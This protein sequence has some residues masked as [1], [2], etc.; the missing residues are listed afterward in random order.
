ML[1][2]PIRK[3]R[4]L[5]YIGMLALCALLGLV[6]GFAAALIDTFGGPAT[7]ALQTG[8]LTL[9]MG[10]V[11]WICVLWWRAADEAVRE[12]HK[13]AWYWGGSAGIVVVILALGLVGWDVIEL[14]PTVLSGEPTELI[15]T[16]V[17]LTLG[18]QL[19]GYL[20]AW[21]AWWLRHR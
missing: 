21:A 2:K 16:G 14:A 17:G 1:D 5:G 19:I 20:I 9:C 11:V 15:M 6:V 8:L 4:R 7:D 3:R 18:A 10:I 12:A 13:W